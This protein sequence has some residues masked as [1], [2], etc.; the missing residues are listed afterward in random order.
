MLKFGMFLFGVVTIT[1]SIFSQSLP[2][3]PQTIDST[4]E[5]GY[6]LA[7]GDV[8]GDKKPDIILA[9]KKQFVWYQ[10]PTWQ[11]HI[12]IENLTERDNVCLAAR[13][14]DGDGKVEIAVGAQWNPGET[15]DESASGSVHY[16]VRPSDPTQKWAVVELAHEPTIHRMGWI[17]TG[18]HFQL[19]VVPLHGRGNKRGAGRGVQIYSYKFPPDV[20]QPWTKTLIDSSMHVTHNFDIVSGRGSEA[21]IIGGKEGSRYYG[22]YDGKWTLINNPDFTI[23][24]RDGFGEIRKSKNFL[25]GIQPFHGNTLAVYTGGGAS[26]ELMTNMNQGHA[27]ACADLLDQGMDQIIVGWRNKNDQEEIGIKIFIAEKNDWTGHHSYWIDQNGMACE[28]LKIA[29]LDLDGKKD[30]IAAGRSSHN[31]KVYWNRN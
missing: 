15:S 24:Q 9:D 26:Q 27:L 17:K 6:G 29:D 4:I 31:L 3:T 2:F 28:D 22:Y 14:L 1:F 10:N 19:V 23:V 30:I 5:I 8:D 18:N 7:I 25:A 12:L 16:L 13:D 20:H 21:L 11:R